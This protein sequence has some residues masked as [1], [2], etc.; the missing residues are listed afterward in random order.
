MNQIATTTKDR[1]PAL[2]SQEN[3]KSRFEDVLGKKA[4]GFMSSV[5]SATK[6]NTSLSKCDPMSV[7]SSAMIAATLDLPINPSLGMAHIVPYKDIATF[8]MGWKGYIQLA[9]RSGQYKT[10]NLTR[11]FD[12]QIKDHNPFTGDYEFTTKRDSDTVIGYLLYFRLIN[13]FEKYVYMTK[14]EVEAHAKRYSVSYRNN[15]GPWKS[16]FDSMALKTVAKMGLSK[17]GILSIEMQKAV[18]SDDSTDFEGNTVYPDGS[19]DDTEKPKKTR[20]KGAKLKEQMGLDNE[21][22]EPG[23]PLEGDILPPDEEFDEDVPL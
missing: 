7:I 11:V 8:Q 15:S 13:G 1:L 10:I 19:L 6:A 21:G 22:Q 18:V 5:I 17:Y 14:G 2:L 16:D 23:E 9:M 4:A 12:G 20:K 3:I